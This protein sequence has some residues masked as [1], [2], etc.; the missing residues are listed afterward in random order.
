MNLLQSG[1]TSPPSRCA[2]P[3]FGIKATQV[4]LH[5]DL[6]LKEEALARTAPA[7][8]PHDGETVSVTE[9][10]ELI[11]KVITSGRHSEALLQRRAVGRPGRA[12]SPTRRA[13]DRRCTRSV[14]QADCRLQAAVDADLDP[15]A[16]QAQELAAEWM[17]LLQQFHGRDEGL[18]ESLYRMQAD[19]AQQIEQQ[20]GGPS[21]DL[22]EFVRPPTPP[23]RDRA[24]VG[25]AMVRRRAPLVVKPAPGGTD[26][27][28]QVGE[29]VLDES[30]VEVH[31][32]L[33]SQE[34]DVAAPA[35]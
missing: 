7:D 13:G 6:R 19:N 12:A 35:R 3:L 23:E 14:A 32:V 15:A 22:L 31:A 27:E 9:F 29:R 18:R 10:L 17:K 5:A 34:S 33:R 11:R 24:V 21:P 4:Y 8:A 1:S 16:P 26:G 20:H 2:S 28:S 25:G 30:P